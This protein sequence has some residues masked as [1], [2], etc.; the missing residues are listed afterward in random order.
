MYN[1]A[2]VGW[3]L[4]SS[5]IASLRPVNCIVDSPPSNICIMYSIVYCSMSGISDLL[6]NMSE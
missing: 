5:I 1:I 2:N 6:T 3:Q 4:A